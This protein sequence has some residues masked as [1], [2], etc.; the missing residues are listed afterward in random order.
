[1]G[2]G[3]VV[4]HLPCLLFH[5]RNAINPKTPARNP[6]AATANP[7]VVCGSRSPLFSV[8]LPS[9]PTFWVCAE[10]VAAVVL[11]SVLVARV[12][13]RERGVTGNFLAGVRGF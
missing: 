2:E 6:A 11:G 5:L 8:L 9:V 12:A 1:M 4:D 10:V 3:A 13:G 7:I